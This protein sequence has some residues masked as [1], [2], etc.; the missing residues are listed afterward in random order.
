[1]KLKEYRQ[2]LGISQREL[3]QK[4]QIPVT[5]LFGWE[6]G[7]REPNIDNLVRIADFY[8]ISIDELVGRPTNMI[9]KMLLS[10]RERNIIDKVLKMDLKQQELTEFYVDTLLGSL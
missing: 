2:K 10:E 5:T 7:A 9:N 4:L 8:N 1:M 6:N 3:S